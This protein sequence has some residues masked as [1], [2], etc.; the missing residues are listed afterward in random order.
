MNLSD[1]QVL[2]R[3][4]PRHV[5]GSFAGGA[6]QA[7]QYYRPILSTSSLNIP[8]KRPEQDFGRG[9]R[10][11][12][13]HLALSSRRSQTLM[14]LIFMLVRWKPKKSMIPFPMSPRTC[15]GF[16][17]LMPGLTSLPC[18]PFWNT[19]RTP[20]GRSRMSP[21]CYEKAAASWLLVRTLLSVGISFAG[22]LEGNIE[23]AFVREDVG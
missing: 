3:N 15:N 8:R 14:G 9:L 12:L 19:F 11:W 17:S 6:E 7:T 16:H 1:V 2:Y 13:E 10:Q 4:S 20:S 5:R 21:R 22:G 23:S 18:M